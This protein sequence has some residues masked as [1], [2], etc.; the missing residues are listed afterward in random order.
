MVINQHLQIQYIWFLVQEHRPSNAIPL[1]PPLMLGHQV[2]VIQKCCIPNGYL[3]YR[4][5]Q[6]ESKQVSSDQYLVV[7][8]LLHAKVFNFDKSDL[9]QHSA[10]N[11]ILDMNYNSSFISIYL[12]LCLLPSLL[13]IYYFCILVAFFISLPDMN[14]SFNASMVFLQFSVDR[15]Q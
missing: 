10:Q 15:G 12:F 14:R 9:T 7:H 5:V 6:L 13:I 1:N 3:S 8:H 4:I 2:H 11:G